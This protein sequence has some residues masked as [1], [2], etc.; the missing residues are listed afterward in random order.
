MMVNNSLLDGE[1][2][3]CYLERGYFLIEKECRQCSVNVPNCEVCIPN[4]AKT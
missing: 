3:E 4:T 1:C 2:S